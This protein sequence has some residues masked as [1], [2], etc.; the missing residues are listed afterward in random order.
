MRQERVD[1]EEARQELHQHAQLQYKDK[2]KMAALVGILVELKKAG[3]KSSAHLIRSNTA[4]AILVSEN[5][6]RIAEHL[7]HISTALATLA[8]ENKKCIN[9]CLTT[10]T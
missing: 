1:I 7:I 2:K 4:L 3:R 6:V 9:F 10:H 8:P 5:K